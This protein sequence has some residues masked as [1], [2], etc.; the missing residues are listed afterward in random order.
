MGSETDSSLYLYSLVNVIAFCLIYVD[1]LVLTSSST[2]FMHQIIQSLT[3]KFALK[4]LGNINYFLGIEAISTK[5]S[6]LLTQ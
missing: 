3:C 6:L 5:D 4:D 1:D 2:K